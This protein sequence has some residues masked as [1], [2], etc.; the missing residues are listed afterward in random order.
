MKDVTPLTLFAW[1]Y[2]Y[3]YYYGI[4]PICQK[5]CPVCFHHAL[6]KTTWITTLL[7]VSF[8]RGMLKNPLC[9]QV[10]SPV[11]TW[12]LTFCPLAQVIYSSC[13]TSTIITCDGIGPTERTSGWIYRLRKLRGFM[14]LASQSLVPTGIPLP[15]KPLSTFCYWEQVGARTV[16][17]CLSRSS[18]G[19]PS[20]Y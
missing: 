20:G 18:T 17:G 4:I 1:Y 3:Y 13:H 12:L 11:Q 14:T 7:I 5:S 9:I 19:T 6:L 8:S 2:Y 10:I 15:S 16:G